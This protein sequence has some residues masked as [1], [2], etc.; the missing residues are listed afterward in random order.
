VLGEMSRDRAR[1]GFTPSETASAVFA[2]KEPL[3]ALAATGDD[4][5]AD[6]IAVSRWVDALGLVTFEH[7]RPGRGP[8]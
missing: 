3:F 5:L 7:P 4:A 1:R 8:S 2:L 6:I